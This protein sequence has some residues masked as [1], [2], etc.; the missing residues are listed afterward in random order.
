MNVN[1]D[2]GVIMNVNV[3]VD[4][5][6]DVNVNVYVYVCMILYTVPQRTQTN[7]GTVVI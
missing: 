4:V 7:W 5:I 6:M 2:V 1:V 3:D